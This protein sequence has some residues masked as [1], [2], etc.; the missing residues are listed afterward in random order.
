M[1]RPSV[2]SL[3]VATAW[4]SFSVTQG[5]HSSS[6]AAVEGVSGFS[7]NQGGSS[8]LFQLTYPP[9][10]PHFTTLL[11]LAAEYYCVSVVDMEH[12]SLD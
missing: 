4:I 11:R 5:A 3:P 7:D 2:R 10:L 12:S 9:L 8:F 6:A 1:A